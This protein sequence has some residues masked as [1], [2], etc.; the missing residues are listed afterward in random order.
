SADIFRPVDPRPHEPQARRTVPACRL[1]RLHPN[2]QR[3]APRRPPASCSPPAA[4]PRPKSAASPPPPPQKNAPAIASGQYPVVGGQTRV[5]LHWLLAPGY[6]LLPRP[7]G[8]AT[9]PATTPLPRAAA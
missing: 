6:W 1:V 7:P 4:P 8:G 9:P 2:Q 5:S 3:S